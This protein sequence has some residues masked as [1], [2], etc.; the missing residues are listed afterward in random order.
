[1][2]ITKVKVDGKDV[3]MNRNQS[4]GYLRVNKENKR[5]EEIATFITKEKKKNIKLSLQNKILVNC[6]TLKEKSQ[7]KNHQ[8]LTKIVATLIEAKQGKDELKPIDP[9]LNKLSEKDLEFYFKYFFKNTTGENKVSP[10]ITE[11]KTQLGEKTLQTKN[12]TLLNQWID[13][14]LSK[15]EH[16]GCSIQHNKID[17]NFENNLD[18]TTSK[19]KQFLNELFAQMRNGEKFDEI[20]D[21]IG[22]K[23]EV[24]GLIC[25]LGKIKTVDDKG[26]KLKNINYD[27]KR[28]LQQ[29][30]Q[31]KIF[32]TKEGPKNRDCRALY[33]YH[34][35]V[36]EYLKLYFPI[37]GSSRKTSHDSIAYYLNSETIKTTIKKKLR[38]KLIQHLLS[39]GKII[40]EE[41]YKEGNDSPIEVNSEKLQI[42]KIQE[43]FK[44]KLSDDITF[45]AIMLENKVTPPS[46]PMI[47]SRIEETNPCNNIPTDIEH[48]N[49]LRQD[50]K[51]FCQELK[52]RHDFE[53]L[54]V[55]DYLNCFEAKNSAPCTFD[56]KNSGQCSDEKLVKLHQLFVDIIDHDEEISENN[57]KDFLSRPRQK[58]MAKMLKLC[59]NKNSELLL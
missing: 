39:C 21:E 18:G 54:A 11:F 16:L 22:K 32:G 44:R 33:A 29:S 9:S 53:P 14:Q 4:E 46:W 45:A 56:A 30:H 37:K 43:T 49:K 47:V 6:Q 7:E 41:H 10:Y 8:K 52:H 57:Q 36:V 40:H 48:K 17:I 31:V 13:K 2:R 23:Y 55:S 42:L 35:E 25:D 51:N 5:K 58:N 1:M 24:D 59:S 20:I 12:F 50:E 27:L 26:E 3:L 15:F 34:H 19:S 28:Y 38:N